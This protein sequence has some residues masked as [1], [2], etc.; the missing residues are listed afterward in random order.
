MRIYPKYPPEPV[1]SQYNASNYFPGN[2]LF[3]MV[4]RKLNAHLAL[5]DALTPIQNKTSVNAIVGRGR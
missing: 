2:L 4:F 1:E 3:T 5:T